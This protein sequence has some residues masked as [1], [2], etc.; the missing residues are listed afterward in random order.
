MRRGRGGSRP[1]RCGRAGRTGGDV[2]DELGDLQPRQPPLPPHPHAHR[3][4]RVVLPRARAPGSVGEAGRLR[5][6]GRS[7]PGPTPEPRG[8]ETQTIAEGRE[9]FALMNRGNMRSVG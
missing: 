4:Q 7:V 5:A 9:D 2:D 8:V 3:R 1:R 6:Q